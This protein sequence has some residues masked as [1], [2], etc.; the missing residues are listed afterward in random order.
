MNRQTVRS[1]RWTLVLLA[2]LVALSVTGLAVAQSSNIFDLGCWGALTGGGDQRLSTTAKLRDSIGL[3][4][5]GT[6]SSNTAI[7]RG[8]NIQQFFA[9][10]TPV[11]T[12]Q[13]ITG[14]N[15]IFLSSVFSFVKNARVCQ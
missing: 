12:P 11:A 3:A 6:T 8:G 1:I 5:V 7:I 2:A 13:P 15:L 10:P 9:A 14:D 4:V